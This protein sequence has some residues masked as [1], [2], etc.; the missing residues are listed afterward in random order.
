MSKCV[1]VKIKKARKMEKKEIKSIDSKPKNK[2]ARKKGKNG[3][4]INR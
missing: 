3:N 4:K 1:K 2:I